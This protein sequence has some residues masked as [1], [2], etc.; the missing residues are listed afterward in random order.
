VRLVAL[1]LGL[2]AFLGDNANYWVGR[3]LGPKLLKSERSRILNRKHLARTHAFFERHGGKTIIMARFVPIVRTF[4]PFVAGVGA[5]TY[6]RFVAYSI[7][8]TVLWIGVCVG[9]GYFFG[10]LP[11]VRKH[12]SLAVLAIILISVAPALVEIVRHK[13]E[14]RT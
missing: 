1:V 5:M 10:G 12:F 11:L 4:T 13:R 9:T 8:A 2:A 3:L 7:A 14:R 6:P